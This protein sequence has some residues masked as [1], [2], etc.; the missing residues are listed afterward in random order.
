MWVNS[1]ALRWMLYLLAPVCPGLCSRILYRMAFH[2]RLD[3][4]HPRTLN[5]KLMWLKL[6]SYRGNSLITQCADKYRVREYVEQ[7]GCGELL[8]ELYGVWERPEEI[9]W[10]VLPESFVLKC[11]HASGFNIICREKESFDRRACEKQLRKWLRRDYWRFRSELQYRDI[12]K[13]IICEKLLGDGQRLIDYKIYCFHGVPTHILA[14]VGREKERPAFYFFDPDWEFCR[15][16]RD[17]ELAPPDFSLPRP[18]GLE[19]ML[20]AAKKLLT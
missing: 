18:K 20:D 14:C 12:P 10:D 8:N 11:N 4:R 13:K 9:A 6:H 7:K 2:R 5:E 15:I 17:G 3:F 16:T 1:R 19:R